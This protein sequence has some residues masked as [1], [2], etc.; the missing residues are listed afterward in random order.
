MRYTRKDFAIGPR[1]QLISGYDFLR[2]AR[3]AHE[4]FLSHSRD[5][6]DG[7]Q[8]EMMKVIAMEEG[9]EFQMTK[10]QRLVRHS[11]GDRSGQTWS[12]PNGLHRRVVGFVGSC[13]TA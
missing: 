2:V 5:L 13:D 8:T 3:W 12:V 6:E 1:Q 9:P 4:E 7:L 11:I 10:P